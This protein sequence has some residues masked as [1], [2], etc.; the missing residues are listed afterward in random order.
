[1]RGCAPCWTGRCPTH[2]P[3]GLPWGWNTRSRSAEGGEGYRTPEVFKLHHGGGATTKVSC[4]SPWSN[5]LKNTLDQ[6][7]EKYPANQM[8]SLGQPPVCHC[9]C[10]KNQRTWLYRIRPSCQHGKF[11]R[12]CLWMAC[13]FFLFKFSKVLFLQFFDLGSCSCL[14]NS[15]ESRG[16]KIF[17]NSILVI[18]EPFYHVF[19]ALHQCFFRLSCAGLCVAN[20]HRI[21]FSVLIG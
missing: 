9:P 12:V 6:E 3:P 13:G 4:L 19:S 8:G 18:F 16:I 15:G 1:M 20:L 17:Q 7:T 14:Q 11:E 10:A 2:L 5:G 21:L